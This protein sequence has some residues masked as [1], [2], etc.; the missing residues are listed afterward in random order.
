MAFEYRDSNIAIRNDLIEAN[1]RAWERIASPGSWWSGTERV[2]LAAEVRA[3]ARCALCAERKAALSPF[4]VQGEHDCE[5]ALPAAAVDLVHRLTTDPGRLSRQWYDDTIAAGLTPDKV[6]ELLPAARHV[7]A[8][9]AS[10]LLPESRFS[11]SFSTPRQ[12][13]PR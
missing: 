7:V 2:A 9:G 11:I 13:T 3:A 6:A 12:G 10:R 8:R 4:A 1:R 5:A